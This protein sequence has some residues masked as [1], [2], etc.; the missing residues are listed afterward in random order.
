MVPRSCF[1]L[2][3]A[4]P[5]REKCSR[6]RELMSAQRGSSCG[7]FPLAPRVLHRD[8]SNQLPVCPSNC[9]ASAPLR[10][11]QHLYCSTG[12]GWVAAPY[13]YSSD[14][15]GPLRPL[16]VQLHSVW[17]CDAVM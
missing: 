6:S 13:R 11:P 3:R 16:Q 1:P 10:A 15:G 2:H 8:S 7:L 5:G 12:C 14:A 17:V 9:G 4:V